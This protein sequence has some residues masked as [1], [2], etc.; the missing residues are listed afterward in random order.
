MSSDLVNTQFTTE[1]MA[2]HNLRIM[3]EDYDQEYALSGV[4][5]VR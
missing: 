1:G 3:R 4:R 2:T 5:S